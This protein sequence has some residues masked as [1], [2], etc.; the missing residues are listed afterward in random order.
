MGGRKKQQDHSICAVSISYLYT[1]TSEQVKLTSISA[2]KVL[3]KNLKIASLSAKPAFFQPIQT[4][5]LSK[6]ILGGNWEHVTKSMI[7]KFSFQL[8]MHV[9][10]MFSKH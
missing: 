8:D 6:I 3:E 2:V 9:T 4:K 10:A 1:T 7:I 5:T